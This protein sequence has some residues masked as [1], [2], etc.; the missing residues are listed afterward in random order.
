MTAI[1][2]TSAEPSR[3]MYCLWAAIT[4]TDDLSDDN[5]DYKNC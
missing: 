2:S 5:Y 3:M 4:A 1:V